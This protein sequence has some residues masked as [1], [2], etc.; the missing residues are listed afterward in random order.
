MF[1]ESFIISGSGYKLTISRGLDNFNLY[2]EDWVLDPTSWSLLALFNV[3]DE[4]LILRV[5][6]N[7]SAAPFLLFMMLAFLVASLIQGSLHG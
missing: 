1:K 4:E 6:R 3:A 2:L 5:R 7:G